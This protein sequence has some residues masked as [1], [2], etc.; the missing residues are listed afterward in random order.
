[1]EILSLL[2]DGFVSS[3]SS[4]ETN[5]PYESVELGTETKTETE[6]E[7]KIETKAK[8]VMRIPDRTAFLW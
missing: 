7:T 8:T 1:M 3:T 6:T 5:Y 2:V 4:T